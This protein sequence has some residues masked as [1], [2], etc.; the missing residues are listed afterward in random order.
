V[1]KSPKMKPNPLFAQNQYITGTVD[2]RAQKFVL[3]LLLSYHCPKKKFAQSGHP[4]DHICTYIHAH[5]YIPTYVPTYPHVYQRMCDTLFS[6]RQRQCTV[7]YDLPLPVSGR[8][9][10]VSPSQGRQWL[11]GKSTQ[12]HFFT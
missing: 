4:D 1:K 3:L 8:N 5:M 6:A 12:C 2:K 11:P 10:S 9:V 7:P